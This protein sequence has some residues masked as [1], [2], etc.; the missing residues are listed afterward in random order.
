MFS[1]SID[2]R[3]SSSWINENGRT[4]THSKL[5]T[6]LHN[7]IVPS[8]NWNYLSQKNETSQVTVDSC[9]LTSRRTGYAAW[10][11]III[12]QGNSS[13]ICICQVM[14]YHMLSLIIDAVIY[15]HFYL[16]DMYIQVQNCGFRKVPISYL[17]LPYTS[18]DLWSK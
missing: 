15:T 14:T 4:L 2:D 16:I 11:V 13:V 8:G 3:K 5:H 7:V 17:C 6:W 18:L 12:A 1:Y 10:D 9:F